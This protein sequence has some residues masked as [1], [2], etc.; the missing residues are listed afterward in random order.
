LTAGRKVVDYHV[1]STHSA[2]G[3]SSILEMC[4]RAVELEIAEIGFAE[5]MDFDP[6]D[7]GFGY[8]DYDRYSSDV[9]KARRLFRRRL[10]IRKG[11]EIDYQRR[12]EGEIRE[13]IQGKRFDFVIGSVHYLGHEYISEKLLMNSGLERIYRAYFAE[14]TKSIESGLFDVVGHLDIVRK[15]TDGKGLGPDDSIYQEGMR[16]VLEKTAEN[17][18]YLEINSKL[19]VL[20][21]GCTD[22]MPS[23]KAVEEYVEKGGRLVSVGSDAHSTGELGSGLGEILDFLAN[24]SENQVKMLFG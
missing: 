23:K 20:R 19:S 15:Y 3:K 14:V 1:H 7:Q 8:F 18:L 24:Y 21:E 2:D 22:T 11:V 12:F 16:T 10:V 4:S 17:K 5:H 6:M 13:W 9:E